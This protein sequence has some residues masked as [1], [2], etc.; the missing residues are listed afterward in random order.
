MRR[1][2]IGVAFSCVVAHAAPASAAKDWS[3]DVLIKHGTV[4]DGSGGPG[5]RA[6]VGL[7]GDKIA[8]V[9]RAKAESAAIVIDATALAVAPG[10]IDAHNHVAESYERA[11]TPF[12]NDQFLTQGVT[13]VLVG[14]DGALS[15]NDLR[16]MFAALQTKGFG[17]N[18]ACYVGHNGIRQEV[19][20]DA[21][22]TA[23]DAELKTMS[24][25]VS[26]GMEL[27]CVGLS[28]GLM[29]EPGMYADEGEVIALAKAVAPFHGTYDSHT[30]A[31]VFHLL[32][33]ETEAIEIGAAAGIPAKLAHEKAVGLLNRGRIWEV[34]AMTEAARARGHEVVA[35]QY[36]YNGAATGYIRQIFIVPGEPKD[37]PV[38][39]A[40]LKEV[41]AV[42]SLRA[43]IRNATEHGI[44]GGFSWVKAVGYGSMRIVD[45]PDAPSLVDENI[46]LLARKRGLEPFDMLVQLVHDSPRDILV[47]VGSVDETDIRELIARPWVMIAS[48]G[49]YIAPGPTDAAHPR[50]TGTFTRVLARYSRELKILTLPEAIRKMTSLP[51]THL[52]L[53]DR[54]RLAPGYAADVTV[55]N[56]RTVSDR[57]TYTDPSARSVGIE[58]VIVSGRLAIRDG[59]L[60]GLAPGRFVARQAAPPPAQR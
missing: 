54:G 7:R 28:T 4:Y 56:P 43:A 6:D 32:E 29:Y 8:F 20:G 60:T 41:L 47:T 58:D 31:P 11:P 18:Y 21:P 15:P 13:T 27:G 5:F 52:H 33:S 53:Y 55:F 44:D 48:D 10:F 30:R 37:A 24:A 39:L 45:A 50:S 59:K 42:P 12:L 17:T 3:F 14:P 46:E 16:K 34:I 36:P 9:G 38:T 35:D 1:F 23:T 40:R 19:I 51:A 57:S 26:E 49:Q 2:I 22:R 25:L